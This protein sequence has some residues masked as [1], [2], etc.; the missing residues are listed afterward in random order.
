MYHPSS[1]G[2][3]ERAVQTFK[4]LM[5]KSS[6]DTLET[7]L[8]RALFPPQSTTGLSP[9]EM[10]MGRKLRCTLDLIHSD[11]K[12]RVESKAYHD[13]HAKTRNFVAGDSVYTR[14]YRWRPKWIPGQ[15]VE[16]TGPLS[17]TVLLGNSWSGVM[18]INCSAD[19]SRICQCSKQRGHMRRSV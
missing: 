12:K 9:A 19:R 2:L 14:N 10:T 1:N 5:K 7:K 4:E 3:A 6:G 8:N 13:K 16:I 17:H 11:L 15:I 18:W